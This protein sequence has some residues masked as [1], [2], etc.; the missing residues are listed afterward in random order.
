VLHWVATDFGDMDVFVLQEV[1]VPE[2]GVGEVTIR[3]RAA[4]IKPAD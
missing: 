3:V 2:S 4:G 1:E